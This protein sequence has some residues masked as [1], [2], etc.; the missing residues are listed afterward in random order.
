MLAVFV[1]SLLRSRMSPGA[2]RALHWLAYLSWPVAVAHT[3]GMGTDAREG[4]VVLLGVAC[5]TSVAVALAWRLRSTTRQAVARTAA[6]PAGAPGAVEAVP[7]KHL[8]L[9]RRGHR[10]PDGA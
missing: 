7:K 5:V 2:W 10:G 6:W 8:A 9:G 4:W 3:F 1:S